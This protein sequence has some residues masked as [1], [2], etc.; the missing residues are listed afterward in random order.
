M[1][2]NASTQ[3]NLR[4]GIIGAGFG[5]VGLAILLKRAGYRA[6]TIF[7]RGAR[8]GGTWRDNSYPG[9]ACDVPSHLY[10]FS[11]AP[12]AD[13][14]DH[15]SPQEEIL[16]YIETTARDFG[17]SELVRLNCGVTSAVFDEA[18]NV[19]AVQSAGGEDFE[20]DI[21]VSAVGQLSQPVIPEFP[22]RAEFAGVQFHAAR[23]DHSVALAGKKIAVVGAAASAIQIVPALAGVAS[24]LTIFQR[25]PN[26][27]IP[28]NNRRY[29]A[30]AR[31]AMGGL[32]VRLGLWLRQEFLFGAFR[33]GSWRNRWVKKMAL[34]NLSD[35]VPDTAL[36][37]ALTPQYELGCKRLLVSDDYYPSFSKPAVTLVTSGISRF[38]AE[39]IR[40]ADGVLHPADVCVFATGFDVRNCLAPIHITGAGGVDLQEAWRDGPQAYW[41]VALPG[42]PNFFMEYGP[43]TNLG[44]SS[45]ILMLEAQARYIVKCL[46]HMVAKGAARIEVSEGANSRFNTWL[47]Q[48]LA[49]TVWT[50]GCG[51]WYGQEG[52]ITANWGRNTWEYIKGMR[53]PVFG[54]FV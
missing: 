18:R 23:W 29:S 11:F 35:Q 46:D 39:G 7:E 43:N 47:Q 30:L 34:K 28:R 32:A 13:W 44:H 49:G 8:V 51:N 45:I 6:I 2:V 50:T 19:W 48:D 38:E 52:K 26:W 54:D 16:S 25:T 14:S 37:A 42:F 36:R 3:G 15:Y 1:P 12:K 5:G 21:L 40:T 41:G 17:V 9:A 22:G 24:E 31:A 53:E 4:V 20:V 33:T 10:S 27:I